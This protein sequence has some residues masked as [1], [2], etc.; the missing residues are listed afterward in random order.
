MKSFGNGIEDMT[1]LDAV[2]DLMDFGHF[3]RKLVREFPVGQSTGS[4]HY[5]IG[6]E[7]TGFLVFCFHRKSVFL[8]G[9]SRGPGQPGNTSYIESLQEE[10]PV[11]SLHIGGEVVQYF[12]DGDPFPFVSEEFCGLAAGHTTA[13]DDNGVTC[14]CFA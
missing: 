8:Y 5:G 12:D 14:G 7:V 9:F 13:D 11:G 6:R 3:P 1:R 10:L 2:A 4:K